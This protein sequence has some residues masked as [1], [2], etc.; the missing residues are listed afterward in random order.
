MGLR[1]MPGDAAD[2]RQGHPGPQGGVARGPSVDR[3]A[4]GLLREPGQEGPARDLHPA[5]GRRRRWCHA[6]LGPRADPG[7]A[8]PRDE[9]EASGSRGAGKPKLFGHHQ[10]LQ[11]HE[12]LGLRRVR[13]DAPD[14][15]QG[16]SRAQGRAGGGVRRPGAA[17]VLQ[18][19]AGPQWATGH[20]HPDPGSCR[21]RSP[22]LPLGDDA[23]CGG[24]A[25]DAHVQPVCH[26]SCWWLRRAQQRGLQ[27]ALLAGENARPPGAHMWHHQEL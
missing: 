22:A 24:A 19:R 27:T 1:R 2:I 9:A 5:A 17:C 18:R 3:P 14:L 15:W 10:V 20:G 7:A 23:A 11:P 16:H 21:C 8:R 26:A 13:G 6:R 4:R 12:G 25:G